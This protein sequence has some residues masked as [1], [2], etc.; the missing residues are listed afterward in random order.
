MKFQISNLGPI[1]SAEINIAP[2]TVICGQN[3]TGKTY[4]SY[5]F[6]GLCDFIRNALSFPLSDEAIDDL[7]ENGEISFGLRLSQD[8]LDIYFEQA[9]MRGGNLLPVFF[10]AP[11]SHFKRSALKLSVDADEIRLPAT[12][13]RSYSIGNAITLQMT[14][15]KGSDFLSIAMI[16]ESLEPI[17]E[18]Q[19]GLIERAIG[20]VIKEILFSEVLPNIM[21]ASAERTGALIF[22]DELTP[23]KGKDIHSLV[24][25]HPNDFDGLVED[26]SSSLY[27]FPVIRNINFVKNLR[28]IALRRSPLAKKHPSLISEFDR[29]SGGAYSADDK[30]VFFSPADNPSLKLAMEESSSSA[31][32]LV[33]ISFWLRHLAKKGDLLMIDEPEMNL[34]PKSQ[35]LLAR[36]VAMLVNCGVKVFITTH[37]DYLVKE[38][39]TL[40]MLRKRQKAEGIAALMNKN[41]ISKEMLLNPKDYQVYVAKRPV[42]IAKDGVISIGKTTVEEAPVDPFYGAA[43]SS[44]DDTITQINEL[45]EA[46]IFNG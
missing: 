23:E 41:G 12:F 20:S 15:A 39:N 29:I 19:R 24:H 9:S 25:S 30:G 11:P 10:A 45:Q 28:T 2:L 40:V 33:L 18:S 36:W 17:K 7:I 22:R 16:N 34:H 27:P 43:V 1:G 26:V 4:A 37:S 46:I 3:N 13:A 8:F 31:R 32:S 42:K 14:K 5:S 35:R 38:L 21:F 44:F 6:Y